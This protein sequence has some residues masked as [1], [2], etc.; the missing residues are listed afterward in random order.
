MPKA[1]RTL[2]EEQREAARQRLAAARARK[3]ELE[4]A[5][6]AEKKVAPQDEPA[7]EPQE[8]AVQDE[9]PEVVETTKNG[10]EDTKEILKRAL[11][12]IET[13]AKLQASGVV[14]QQNVPQMRNNKVVGVIE[15]YT[16]DPETYPSPVERIKAEERLQQFAFPYN[17]DLKYEVTTTSYETKDGL[18]YIEPKFNLELHR[19]VRDPLTGDDSGRRYVICRLVMHEDP[20]TALKVARDNNIAVDELAEQDFLN[21]MRYLQMRDWVLESFYHPISTNRSDRG[22]MVVDGKIVEFFEI[23]DQNSQKLP[24]SDLDKFRA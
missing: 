3:A 21:E 10:E 13:L 19:I 14:S 5:R 12:A 9:A 6:L 20:Q 24:F 18:N 16:L 8:E 4:A 7:D 23:N 2:T 11:E 15:K 17:Y 1:K 22:E